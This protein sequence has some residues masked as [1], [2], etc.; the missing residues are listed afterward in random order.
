MISFLN[1]FSF[2]KNDL[3]SVQ[4]SLLSFSPLTEHSFEAL[5]NHPSRVWLHHM[6]DR[7]VWVDY[8]KRAGVNKVFNE[9]TRAWADVMG[10]KQ[11]EGSSHL[12]R[13]ASQKLCRGRP[14]FQRWPLCLCL[15]TQP[16]KAE[17]FTRNTF[18]FRDILWASTRCLASEERLWL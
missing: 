7:R 16:S 14:G 11:L 9:H 3:W 10:N 12:C 8:G 18:Q 2:W 13:P 17:S 5:R 15:T 1:I 6:V 4:L